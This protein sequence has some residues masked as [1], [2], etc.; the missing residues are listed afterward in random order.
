MNRKRMPT[1]PTPQI[2]T[3]ASWLG[4]P[5]APADFPSTTLRWRNDRWARTVGLDALDDGEWVAHFGRFAPLADNL[6]QPLALRYHG[7]QFGVYNPELGDGRGFLFAQCAMA[8]AA[9]SIWAPKVQ[10]K[11][12]GAGRAMGA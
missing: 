12:R 5:V 11:R 3:L 8:V 10:G 7:H 4:D 6:P 2:L 1:P 9:C